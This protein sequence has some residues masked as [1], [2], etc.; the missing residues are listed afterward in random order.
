MT[1]KRCT[2]SALCFLLVDT[3]F[4][5]H[6]CQPSP[7]IGSHQEGLLVDSKFGWGVMH[8]ISEHFDE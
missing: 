5:G 8:L 1:T 2:Y 4:S 6:A 3:S 7:Y